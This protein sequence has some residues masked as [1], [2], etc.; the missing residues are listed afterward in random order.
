MNTINIT[1]D[2]YSSQ[3]MPVAREGLEYS[4]KNEIKVNKSLDGTYKILYYEYEFYSIDPSV[5]AANVINLFLRNLSNC[6]IEFG[7]NYYRA[8]KE[9]TE[10]DINIMIRVI[11]F[12]NIINK[13]KCD[14]ANNVGFTY[15]ISD[16]LKAVAAY[17][18]AALKNDTDNTDNTDNSNDTD[19][20]F[21]QESDD[22]DDDDEDEDDEDS[23]S[24]LAKA[25]YGLD[26]DDD[27]KGKK[28]KSKKEYDSSRV[29]KVAKN[30]K[31]SYYRHGV[32]ICPNKD[33]IKKDE[34]IIKEFLK[35]FIPGNSEWKKEFRDDLIK[36]WIKM[37]VVTSKQLK[38]LEKQYRKTHVSKRRKSSID[39]DKALEFT[40]RLF[41]TPVDRWNDP[42]R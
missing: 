18:S 32:M 41:N 42:S 14:N 6:N 15:I 28:K 24:M 13:I 29:M 37:Y 35:D 39:T 27:S 8:A 3:N 10:D 4:S 16:S 36:R 11:E 17:L 5:L 1:M 20:E 23:V 40:R 7:I 2:I 33:A 21:Y 31:R 19:Y 30:P 34:K 22:E 9:V 12:S 25:L 38:H 26:L